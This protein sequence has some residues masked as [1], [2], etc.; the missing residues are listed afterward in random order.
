MA[1]IYIEVF[2][3]MIVLLVGNIWTHLH[4]NQRD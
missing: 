2:E 4:K 3:R 1:P